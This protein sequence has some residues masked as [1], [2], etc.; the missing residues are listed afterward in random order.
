MPR[1]EVEIGRHG[2][3]PVMGEFARGLAVPLVPAG[4]VVDHH[5]AGKR[6]GANWTRTIGIDQIILKPWDG[7]S[8]RE[9]AFVH[10]GL[11]HGVPSCSTPMAQ[12][13]IVACS[14]PA[15]TIRG[16]VA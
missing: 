11:I 10:V 13:L 5:D 4:H 2:N 3:I 12:W 8:F 15:P 6:S 16:F 1:A 7:D 14:T 9:H